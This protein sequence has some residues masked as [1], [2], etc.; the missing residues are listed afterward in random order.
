MKKIE[1]PNLFKCT[2]CGLKIPYE[3]A[4]EMECGQCSFDDWIGVKTI[5]KQINS[6]DESDIRKCGFFYFV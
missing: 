6:D 1:I 3:K 5:T 4:G 2:K